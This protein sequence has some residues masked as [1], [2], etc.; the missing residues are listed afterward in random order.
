MQTFIS[1]LRGINVSGHRKINMADL[2]ALYQNLGYEDAVTYIQSGNVIFRTKDKNEAKISEAIETAINKQYQF[3]VPVI[4]R[5]AQEMKAIA[6]A[7]PFIKGNSAIDQAKLHVTFL[8][9]KPDEELLKKIRQYNYAPD[10]FII[11]GREVYLY[12]PGGYGNTKL[13]NQFFENKLKVK[14][15]TRNWKTINKLI[16]LAEGR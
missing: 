10:E 15:T 12:C 14:A 3:D 16:D 8:G 1:V 2:K 11:S 6:S 7:N 13:S 4:I 5:T 9:E